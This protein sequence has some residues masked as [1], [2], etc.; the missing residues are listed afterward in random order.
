MIE[1]GQVTITLTPELRQLALEH[2]RE[3][4]EGPDAEDLTRWF[5]E[6]ETP[7]G[8]VLDAANAE[9]EAHMIVVIARAVLWEHDRCPSCRNTYQVGTVYNGHTATCDY[10]DD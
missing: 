2:V 1:P 7:D 9:C 8:Y 6:Q 10:R 5:Q 3:T 4:E